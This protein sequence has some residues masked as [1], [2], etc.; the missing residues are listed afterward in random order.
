MA[1]TLEYDDINGN[2]AINDNGNIF[3]IIKSY[4]GPRNLRQLVT[5]DYDGEKEQFVLNINGQKMYLI[6]RCDDFGFQPCACEHHLVTVPSGYY[7]Q[8][9]SIAHSL[10]R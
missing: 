1:V 9:T 10:R 3:P 6:G 5:L 7:S 2:V 8:P 4:R